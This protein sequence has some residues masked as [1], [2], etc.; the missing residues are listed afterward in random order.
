MI[1][2][3]NAVRFVRIFSLQQFHSFHVAKAL[4]HLLRRMQMSANV[5]SHK[6]ACLQDLCQKY[7]HFVQQCQHYTYYVKHYCACAN[8][9]HDT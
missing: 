5:F 7:L 4:N 1:D 3:V 2:F 6:I 9:S 8:T